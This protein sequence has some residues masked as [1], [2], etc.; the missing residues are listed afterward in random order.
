M[1]QS[2]LKAAKSAVKVSEVDGFRSV[3]LLSMSV[4]LLQKTLQG[5]RVAEHQ[6]VINAVI[7]SCRLFSFKKQK[8]KIY[9]PLPQC[10]L[11]HLDI[12]HQRQSRDTKSSTIKAKRSFPN[13]I[14]S[15]KQEAPVEQPSADF[16]ARTATGD[17]F[18]AAFGSRLLNSFYK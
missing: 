12:L 2:L 9:S 17:R 14:H 18:T 8:Q 13:L 1:S 4:Q 6:T 5:Y 3:D 7:V 11:W 15:R 16:L 10:P